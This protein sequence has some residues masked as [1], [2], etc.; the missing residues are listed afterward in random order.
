MAELA[1]SVSVL[2]WASP[3]T[4]VVKVVVIMD[5]DID[6]VSVIVT[7]LVVT[8]AIALAELSAF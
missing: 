3:L 2:V 1:D 4:V 6:A 7:T 8:D 5:T